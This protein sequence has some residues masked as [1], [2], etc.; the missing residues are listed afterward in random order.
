MKTRTIAMVAI[1][2]M[3]AV[4]FGTAGEKGK[5]FATP[6][7]KVAYATKNLMKGLNS[8]NPGV[9]E[10]SIRL[11]AQMKMRFPD[12]DVTALQ[13]VLNAISTNHKSGCVRYQAYIAS[14]ICSDPAWFSN[15]ESVVTAEQENFFRAASNRLQQRLYTT[16]I[17]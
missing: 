14:N 12:T 7:E 2:M 10:A 15:D 16:N 5:K 4:Q 6:N 1:A 11:T 13:D 8:T 3:I 17:N 9:V